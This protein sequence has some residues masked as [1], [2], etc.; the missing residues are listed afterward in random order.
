MERVALGVYIVRHD[1]AD[2]TDPPEDVGVGIEEC[3][4]LQ[5]LREIATGCAVL[6][7]LMYC[8]NLSYPKDTLSNFFR[9]C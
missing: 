5:D 2:A 1:G 7:G 6:F 3:T 9:K 4:V 8:L